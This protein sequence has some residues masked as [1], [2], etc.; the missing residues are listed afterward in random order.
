MK[1]DPALSQLGC[2]SIALLEVKVKA[3]G[4]SACFP[5]QIFQAHLSCRPMLLDCLMGLMDR[6]FRDSENRLDKRLGTMGC[7]S[8]RYA[9]HGLG[10]FLDGLGR[11]FLQWHL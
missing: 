11:L 8:Y 2:E 5:I 7:Q 6:C 4:G 1:I 9:C 3:C 10:S